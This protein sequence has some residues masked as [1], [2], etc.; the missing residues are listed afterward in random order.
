MLMNAQVAL[1]V[2]VTTVITQLAPILAVVLVVLS[3]EQMDG[4]VTVS[5]ML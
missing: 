5:A 2:V 3:L 4:H 1:I